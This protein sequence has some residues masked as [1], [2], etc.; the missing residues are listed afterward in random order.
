MNT[1]VCAYVTCM[2]S[3][4]GGQRRHWVPWNWNYRWVWTNT[5]V[6]RSESGQEQQQLLTTELSPKS[7]HW[8][9]KRRKYILDP[10][11]SLYYNWGT[12]NSL[13]KFLYQTNIL[14]ICTFKERSLVFHINIFFYLSICVYLYSMTHMWGQRKT[15][16]SQFFLPIM[17]A[18]GSNSSFVRRGSKR[19][20]PMS[21]LAGPCVLSE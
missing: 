20:Y 13:L 8:E 7:L 2:H 3:V 19:L 18:G 21:H 15:C 1:W 11:C 16:L 14:I 4:L 10:S 17:W 6:L 5:W 12:T 9:S